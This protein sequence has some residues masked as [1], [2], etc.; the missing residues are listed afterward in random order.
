MVG[1]LAGTAVL[2]SQAPAPG[3]AHAV[4]PPATSVVKRTILP[5]G[6]VQFE[7]ADGTTKRVAGEPTRPAGEANAQNASGTAGPDQLAPIV[8][9]AWLKDPATNNLF[10]EAMGAYY[11]Y[12]SSGLQHRRRV[13]EWQLLSSK[14]IF[15]TVLMLVGTG[16]VFAALQFRA[17][18]KRTL[19]DGRDAATEVALSTTSLKVSS[20]VL[21]VIIL[22][23]SLAFFYLY[24]VYVY[25]ISELV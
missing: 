12:K 5:D 4:D 25:P 3:P 1:L 20:P 16:I 24:L 9:P 21:G 8:P 23:I 6:T 15:V 14:I 19:A 13:F 7:Y 2:V 11:V 22:V 17:G 10:L 18:L